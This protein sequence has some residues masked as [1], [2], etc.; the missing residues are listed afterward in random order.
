MVKEF[1]ICMTT[2]VD[3]FRK[4]TYS[5]NRKSPTHQSSHSLH[6]ATLKHMSATN[7]TPMQ[8]FNAIMEDHDARIREFKSRLADL[9]Q[10]TKNIE[11][12]LMGVD[13]ID[14]TSEILEIELQKLVVSHIDNTRKHQKSVNALKRQKE[15]YHALGINPPS[16]GL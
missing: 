2:S 7:T 11:S 13:A 4:L 9:E 5:Y 14:H 16:C 12:A 3:E 1:L 15:M 10:R 8:V 6:F